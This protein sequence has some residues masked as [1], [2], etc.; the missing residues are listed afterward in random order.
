M[1][2]GS[3]KG[4]LSTVGVSS[5]GVVEHLFRLTHEETY[6]DVRSRLES[7]GSDPDEPCLIVFTAYLPQELTLPVE[8]MGVKIKTNNTSS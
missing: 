6:E 8:F 7:E 4:I 5:I 2:E 3:L 1:K